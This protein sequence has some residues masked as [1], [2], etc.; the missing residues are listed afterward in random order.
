MAVQTLYCSTALISHGVGIPHC[1]E[2]LLFSMHGKGMLRSLL[3]N[4]PTYSFV[5]QFVVILN[6]IHDF[7]L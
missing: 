2:T 4:H 6:L 5:I 7:D 1:S 3:G